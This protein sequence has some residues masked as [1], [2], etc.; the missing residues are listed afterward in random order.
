MQLVYAVAVVHDLEPAHHVAG[1]ARALFVP[2]PL[3]DRIVLTLGLTELV[4]VVAL[5]LQS[6]LDGLD[7]VLAFGGG[8]VALAVMK[9]H[10][11][12]VELAARP[13]LV[14]VGLLLQQVVEV[15]NQLLEGNGADS[16]CL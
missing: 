10:L 4:V 16:L 13:E 11:L 12:R 8:A 9:G 6:P 3:A 14:V 5:G 1:D 7:V 2:D 15:R